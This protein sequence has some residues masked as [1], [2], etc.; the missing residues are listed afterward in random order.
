MRF[1]AELWRHAGDD[2]W[3]FVTVPAHV[4]DEIRARAA[5]LHR[6]FGSLP[7][8][9]RIGDVAWRTSLFSDTKRDAYLLPVK[10]QV[11]RRAKVGAGDLL[12]VEVAV[13]GEHTD[14]HG[15]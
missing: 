3:Y 12:D 7:V 4:T 5:G 8:E 2:G 6:P 14:R 15:P 11:R 10:A 1:T 13:A 9:A